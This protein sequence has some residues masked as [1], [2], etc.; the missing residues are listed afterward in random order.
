MSTEQGMKKKSQTGG[1]DGWGGGDRWKR[2]MEG[3]KTNNQRLQR[4]FN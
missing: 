2:K 1:R 3:A 4:P